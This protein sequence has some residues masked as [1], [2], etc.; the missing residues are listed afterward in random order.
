MAHVRKQIRDRMESIL[1]AGVASVSGRVYASRVYPLTGPDLP[2]LA[3][4]TSSESSGLQTMGV[5]TLAR[6]IS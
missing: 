4:Y 6:D 5:R 2:A 3:V 1:A